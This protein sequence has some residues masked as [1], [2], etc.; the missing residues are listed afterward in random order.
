[1]RLAIALVCLVGCG[2]SSDDLHVKT[3]TGVVHGAKS[4][5]VRS[6]LGIPYAAAPVGNLRWHAPVPAAVWNGTLETIAVGSQCPQTLSYAGPSFDEDCLFLNVWT[7]TGAHDLPVMVWLHGGAFI[8]GSGGDKYY[9]GAKLADHG[10]VV[11]TINYRLG[12]LGFMTHPALDVE[13]PQ[14]PTSG[15]YGLEDQRFALQWVQRNI[16]AFGGDPKHVTLFGE[17]AG[18]FS[19]CMHYLS[20]RTQDLFAA[21][22]SESGLCGATL[23]AP[24]HAVAESQSLTLADQLGCPGNGATALACLRGIDPMTLLAATALPPA[25]SMMPGGPFYQPAILPAVLPNVDGY[26]FAQPMREAFDAHAFAPRPLLLGSNKDEGTL[27]H[28]SV[29]A[30]PVTDDTSYRAAL[31]V[32]F[33]AS[34]VAAI[35]AQ[36]PI[37]SYP[38]ANDAIAAVTGDAFFV[39]PTRHSVRGAQAGGAPVFRYSFE[40]PLESPFMQGLGVFHSSEL[41]F[42]FGNDDY[43]LGRIGA[44]APLSASIQDYWTTFAKTS[45]PNSSAETPWPAYDAASDAYLVL[46][47]PAASGSQLKAALCDFW[48]ALP[49]N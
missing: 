41:P 15:N 23:L 47:T 17:S 34:N 8:F 22:I 16:A 45:D 10:V 44:G 5:N 1:M 30:L 31:T 48:D 12:V 25:T 24:S 33:G 35:V 28:S 40:Q 29:Y 18:G 27:F 3:E 26:V 36:Y 21:A 7:P 14:Y 4:G 11:V 37:A 6:F 20:S 32:R 38:S 2:T 39:C 46:A 42:V 13:D 9:D 43:P 49:A 19:T